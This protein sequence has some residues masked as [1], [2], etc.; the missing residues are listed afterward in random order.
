MPATLVSGVVRNCNVHAYRASANIDYIMAT[1]NA[2]Y[3]INP[4]SVG[5]S[6]PTKDSGFYY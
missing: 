1:L 5:G 2:A 3:A 4:T 6:V